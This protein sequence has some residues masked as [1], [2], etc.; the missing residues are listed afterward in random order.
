M[1]V[2]VGVWH[3]VVGAVTTA[4]VSPKSMYAGDETLRNGSGTPNFVR[5]AVFAAATAGSLLSIV[6]LEIE[7]NGRCCCC[8]DCLFCMAAAVADED[9]TPKLN[10][11]AFIFE[12]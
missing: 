5:C 1:L 6:R 4:A 8:F 2:L 3:G 11:S 10:F 7:P 9:V 12:I